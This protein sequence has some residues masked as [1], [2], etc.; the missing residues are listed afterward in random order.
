MQIVPVSTDQMSLLEDIGRLWKMCDYSMLLFVLNIDLIKSIIQSI[1][2]ICALWVLILPIFPIIKN[3]FSSNYEKYEL[4]PHLGSQWS[5]KMSVPT[6]WFPLNIN[7]IFKICQ[8]WSSESDNFWHNL[9]TFLGVSTRNVVSYSFRLQECRF[10]KTRIGIFE[11]KIDKVC[12]ISSLFS[13]R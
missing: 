13:L 12:T 7:L 10:K 6:D 11:L 1:Y 5:P 9:M 2:I 3:D 4:K 8:E